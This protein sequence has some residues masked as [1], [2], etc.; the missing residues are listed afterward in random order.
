MLIV[1]P[2]RYASSRFPGKPLTPLLGKP[3]IQW[4]W[5]AANRV[6]GARVVV[7][8]DDFR[9]KDVLDEIGAEVVMTAP[10]WANG[11]E[12]V[13]EAV[14]WLDAADQ[15]VVNWQGDAL[16]IDPGV[17]PRLVKRLVDSGAPVATP[18][19]DVSGLEETAL[20]RGGVEAVLNAA[21]E[22]LWFTRAPVLGGP[23][24]ARVGMYAYRGDALADYAGWRLSPAERFSGLEQLRWLVEGKRV[25]ALPLAPMVGGAWPEVNYPADV[26]VVEKAL[27]ARG[28]VA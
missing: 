20:P 9:I 25:A 14:E 12:R 2:A 24:T 5:E 27:R 16:L 10:D 17:V 23:F 4:T 15:V 8:T 1:I 28:E 6:G 21:G 11:T 22:C 26:A 18:V 3:L 7:A 13:A 19:V